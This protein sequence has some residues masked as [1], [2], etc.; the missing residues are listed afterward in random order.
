MGYGHETQKTK[1]TAKSGKA[2]VNPW[3]STTARGDLPRFSDVPGLANAIDRVIASGDALVFG[4]TSDGGALSITL[5]CGNDRYKIYAAN[6]DELIR[7][8]QA[9][10]GDYPDPWDGD[11]RDEKA[12]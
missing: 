2:R 11:K 6:D 4:S 5:L 3:G 10:I 8:F 7:A 9:L 1:T 12:R